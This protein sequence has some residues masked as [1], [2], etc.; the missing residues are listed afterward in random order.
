MRFGILNARARSAGAWHRALARRPDS[1]VLWTA[2]T[3]T[4]GV[5]LCARERPDLLLIDLPTLGANGLQITSR[6][7]AVSP[8]AIVIVTDSV[9]TN[10][11]FLF[12]AMGHGAVDVVDLPALE[13]EDGD[14][15]LAA[16]LTKVDTIGTLLG[17][18]NARALEARPAARAVSASSRGAL[19]VVGASAGGPAA[20]ATLLRGIPRAWPGAT[21][22]VQHIDQAFVDGTARWLT[23]RSGHQ[24]TVAAAGE[25]PS[26]GRVLL[27]GAGGH[28]TMNAAGR[29][30]YTLEPSHCSY[31]PSVDV[32][33]E[34][35]CRWWRGEVIGVL[36]TGM[37]RDGAVGL[38]ALRDKGYH[39]IAQD[40]AS[41]AVYGMPKAAVAL[42]AAVD[43][44][45]LDEIAP[46]VI[47]RLAR[48]TCTRAW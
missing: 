14:V 26:A 23:E 29:L 7:M 40:E 3:P 9:R 2:H 45:P 39:T 1:H 42:A 41:S 5:Q 13:D 48:H 27:A 18:S 46:R 30:A 15:A 37:G 31:R 34:S 24:V 8:C 28:L 21:V 16:L 11:A 35:V 19:L 47:D 20:L 17:T 4:E 33:F 44:L 43:V 32:F 38:K 36:L 12:E 25:Q 6:I 10:A 22:L